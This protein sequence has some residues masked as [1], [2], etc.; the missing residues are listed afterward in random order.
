M[1]LLKSELAMPHDVINRPVFS[2]G[3]P[4]IFLGKLHHVVLAVLQH[5]LIDVHISTVCVGLC[6]LT[7]RRRHLEVRCSDT[8]AFR[9][10]YL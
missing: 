1:Q 4:E 5:S 6:I 2:L 7:Y 8:T 3:P 10:M 9:G